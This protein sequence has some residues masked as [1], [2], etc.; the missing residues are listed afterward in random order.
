MSRN[1]ELIGFIPTIKKP[2]E[3]EARAIVANQEQEPFR[4]VVCVFDAGED[5]EITITRSPYLHKKKG[6]EQQ[7]DEL[8]SDM[9]TADLVQILDISER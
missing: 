4:Q 1:H 7:I 5:N 3:E 8:V 9:Q 2:S 6:M